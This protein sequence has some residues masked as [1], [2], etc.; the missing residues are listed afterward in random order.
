MATRS[1]TLEET[2]HWSGHPIAS[3]LISATAI[4]LPLLASFAAAMLAGILLPHATTLSGRV[5]WWAAVLGT[6]T[7][8]F[9]V[10]ERGGRRLLPLSALLKM[11]MVFPDRAP[12]RLAV[13][14]RIGLTR[15]LERRVAGNE[16]LG[17]GKSASVATDILSLAAALSGH[18]RRTRGHAERV[19]AYTDMIA[20]ELKLPAADRDRLRW[21]ALLHD[22]GKLAVHAD[23]LNKVGGPTAEE[24]EELRRHPLEGARL[25]Q[26]LAGWLGEWSLTVEQHHEQFGGGGYPYGLSGSQLSLGARIVGVADSF[27]A[28]T[29]IRS[30]K[31][32]INST[33]AREELTAR[34]GHTVRPCHRPGLSQHLAR[35]AAMDDGASLVA[36]RRARS[37]PGSSPLGGRSHSEYRPPSGSGLQWRA[38]WRQLR[39]SRITARR[40]VL[41]PIWSRRLARRAS[42]PQRAMPWPTSAGAHHSTAAAR[43]RPT[44]SPPTRPASLAP[45]CSSTRRPRQSRWAASRTARA[46]HSR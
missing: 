31:K 5:L 8:V 45:L 19:R 32:P 30:Y 15:D 3:F 9:V 13:A 18:D 33:A 7:A 42:R 36:D 34:R 12:T 23:I 35:P 39:R 43:S 10:V 2:R 44:A 20:T 40:H 41:Q 37:C 11:T 14:R 22:V 21:S 26:P 17:Y 25:I 24:W 29:S 1:D 38:D 6:S 28:M 46:T 16:E 27:D 4:L